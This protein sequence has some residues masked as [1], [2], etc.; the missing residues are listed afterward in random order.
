MHWSHLS[1]APV[2]HL[3]A[4]AGADLQK[5]AVAARAFA[6]AGVA[7][8]Q[9]SFFG[10]PVG[11]ARVAAPRVLSITNR[12]WFACRTPTCPCRSPIR[13]LTSSAPGWRATLPSRIIGISR[14]V[15]VAPTRPSTTATCPV[16]SMRCRETKWRHGRQG[17]PQGERYDREGRTWNSLRDTQDRWDA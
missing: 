14:I 6:R 15:P 12:A 1:H 9:E 4:M 2:T 5:V 10:F 8:Q 16:R 13:A 11:I 17:G 3:R 7:H